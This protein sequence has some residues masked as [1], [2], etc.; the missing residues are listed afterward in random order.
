[1]KKALAFALCL[2]LLLVMPVGCKKKDA[3]KPAKL[4]EDRIS[5]DL[6]SN[7]GFYNLYYTEGDYAISNLK[8]LKK[9]EKKVEG[10]TTTY[11][12]VSATAVNPCVRTKFTA[13]MEYALINSLWKWQKTEIVEQSSKV[14]SGPNLNSVRSSIYNYV[15]AVGSALAVQGEKRYDLKPN[16]AD[17]AWEMKYD[18][19][20]TTARLYLT[21]KNKEMELTGYY[22]LHFEEKGWVLES[23]TQKDGR[24]FPVLY[25]ENYKSLKK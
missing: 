18:A 9:S 22:G 6:I 2:T 3:A 12:T 21:I 19:K 4:T 20:T 10:V 16:L 17:A 7:S 24:S 11:L 13:K 14:L 8:I 25:L 5:S 15:S 23:E 1:M